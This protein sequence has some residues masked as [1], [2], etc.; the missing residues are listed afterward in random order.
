MGIFTQLEQEFDYDM[1]EEFVGHFQYMCD[2]MEMLCMHLDTKENYQSSINELFRIFHNLKSASGYFDLKPIEKLSSL[3][4]SVLEDARLQNGHATE[5]F[6]V[7][8]SLLANQY[9]DWLKNLEQ[10]DE[11]LSNINPFILKLPKT[12]TE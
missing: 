7:W 10:D 5:E 6:S 12:I 3:V 11:E 9:L 8:L 2:A 4:E 1:V